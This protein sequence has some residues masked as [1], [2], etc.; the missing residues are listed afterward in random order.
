MTERLV[1]ALDQGTTSS[2]AIAFDRQGRVVASAQREL[3][4]RFPSP[5]HVT[6]DPEAIW[7]SQIGVAREVVGRVGGA[8]HDGDDDD[9]DE[10]D[11]APGSPPARLWLRLR[12]RL[13]GAHTGSASC[14]MP[15]GA[16]RTRPASAAPTLRRR[17]VFG[18]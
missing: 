5:G 16:T 17:P 3:E 6:H 7:E 15:I 8:E 1:L 13:V 10:R 18:R 2:R 11:V 12:A 14:G 4:Q 9:G